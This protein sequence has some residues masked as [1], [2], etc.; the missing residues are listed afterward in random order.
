MHRKN[1]LHKDTDRTLLLVFVS[2]IHLHKLDHRMIRQRKMVRS[3]RSYSSVRQS[4]D[5]LFWKVS[6]LVLY[7]QEV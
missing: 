4:R 1:Y 7:L 2:L 5:D 6:S 3:W